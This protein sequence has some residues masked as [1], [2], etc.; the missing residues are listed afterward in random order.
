MARPRRTPT[1]QN[2]APG[3]APDGAAIDALYGLEPVF[4]PESATAELTEFAAVDC[5]YCGESYSATIDL[6][7]G[8]FCYMEDCQICCQPIELSGEIDDAGLLKSLA[9]RRID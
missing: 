4:E 1:P 5:P 3:R 2:V 8:S 9:G 7:A 6:S